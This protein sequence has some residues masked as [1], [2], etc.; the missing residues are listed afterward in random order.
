MERKFLCAIL[1]ASILLSIISIAE[2]VTFVEDKLDQQQPTCSGNYWGTCYS[3]KL[4]QSF[5]PK[6]NVLTRIEVFGFK[7][8]SPPNS[9]KISIRSSLEGNDITSIVISTSEIKLRPEGGWIKAEFPDINVIPGSTYFIVWSPASGD[10]MKPYFWWGYDQ[11]N[12]GDDP[13]DRGKQY[14]KDQPR[15]WADFC[16]KTYGYSIPAVDITS[17]INGYDVSGMVSI[18]GN[19]NDTDGTVQKVEVKI[20]NG[21]WLT[22]TGTTNWNYNW[23]TITVINGMHNIEAR[24]YDGEFY[25]N[26]ASIN[27]YVKNSALAI[28]GITG[29]YEIVTVNIKNSGDEDAKNVDWDIVLKG[30]FFKLLN[31]DTSGTISTLQVDSVYSISTDEKIFGLGPI[32]ISVSMKA[33]NTESISKDFEGFVLGPFVII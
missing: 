28:E 24:S 16:F 22:A 2:E 18:I 1:S 4:A 20:D 32:E 8:E 31:V 30:G 6:L 17:P 13:Y 7:N 5:K 3:G 12:P 21:N 29:G 23:D 11:R 19:A 27:L 15:D 10:E 26:I 25:S 14:I 33:D 9:L